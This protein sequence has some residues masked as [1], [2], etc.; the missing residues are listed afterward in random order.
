MLRMSLLHY[1]TPCVVYEVSMD[2]FTR[3]CTL[4]IVAIVIAPGKQ[5]AKLKAER[6]GGKHSHANL[7]LEIQSA[8]FF[9]LPFFF[10]ESKFNHDTS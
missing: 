1:I 6:E 5:A 3:W 7:N 10:F 8:L 4:I 2:T 9:F